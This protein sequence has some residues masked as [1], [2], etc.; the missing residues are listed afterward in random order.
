[1]AKSKRS[2]K[3]QANSL[4]KETKPKLKDDAK[5]LKTLKT[6]VATKTNKTPSLKPPSPSSSNHFNQEPHLHVLIS[7]SGYDTT[8][9]SLGPPN[10]KKA[11]FHPAE[12]KLSDPHDQKINKELNIYEI[13]KLRDR[14]NWRSNDAMQM[15]WKKGF[16]ETKSYDMRVSFVKII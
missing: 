2:S 10:G 3:T 12:Q 5:I 14:L 7:D 4:K 1:M 8:W 6:L 15:E 13:V 11:Y 16:G 9:A